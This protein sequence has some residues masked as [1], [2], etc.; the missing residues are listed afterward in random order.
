MK[1]LQKHEN[2]PPKYKS[3][4]KKVY[5]VRSGAQTKDNLFTQ[6][7]SY[8]LQ[9]KEKKRND[10]NEKRTIDSKETEKTR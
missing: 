8:T 10:K 6:S 4:A 3:P 2:F 1:A 5:L 7:N 9:T